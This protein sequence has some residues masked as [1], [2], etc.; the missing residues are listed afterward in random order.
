MNKT[1]SKAKDYAIP[2][3][4]NKF[5]SDMH[6]SPENI[7]RGYAVSTIYSKIDKYKSEVYLFERKY[8]C[9]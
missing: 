1:I 5:Y 2:E 6:I 8:K 4:I 3:V 7:L 9:T